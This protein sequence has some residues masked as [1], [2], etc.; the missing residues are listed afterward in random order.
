VSPEVWLDAKAVI[1]ATL[2]GLAS[3]SPPVIIFP[4]YP[5]ELFEPPEPIQTWLSIDIGGD[6]AEPIELGGKTW[7]ETGAIWLHLMLP[8]GD[9]IENGLT[10]RK[11]FSVAFRAAI[12]TVQ[13]LYY[14]DQSFD[15]LGAED[16]VWRRLSL[17]I[18]YEF[19]DIL[20]TA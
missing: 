10:W 1:D 7:E 5:N 3:N 13:G 14:R 19:N 4:E 2:T 12:P 16:G 20:I 6:V 8:I 15:P 18:R 17:I 9:G 11:A